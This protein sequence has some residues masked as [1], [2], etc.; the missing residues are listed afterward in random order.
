[1]LNEKFVIVGTIISFIDF[2]CGTLSLAGLVLW[3]VTKIGNIAILFSIFADG[4]A[5]IPTLIKSY[6]I[7]ETENYR[8]FL[9]GAINASITL[10]TIKI[11]SLAYYAFPFYIL[12]INL[13]LFILIKFKIGALFKR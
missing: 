8:P 5:A 7:P 2:L 9:A 6:Y 13:F 3:Y 10:L 12:F 1:M 4:T 11:W